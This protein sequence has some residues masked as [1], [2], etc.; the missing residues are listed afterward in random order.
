MKT[1]YAR[2]EINGKSV[3]ID[4]LSKAKS[5]F[6]VGYRLS[7]VNY[8]LNMAGIMDLGQKEVVG[9]AVIKE[10]ELQLGCLVDYEDD[11]IKAVMVFANLTTTKIKENIF[12]IHRQRMDEYWS[13]IN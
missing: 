9:G 3:E 1:Q 7:S 12:R 13:R 6:E 4:T 2:L 10:I 8:Y 5:I 11:D